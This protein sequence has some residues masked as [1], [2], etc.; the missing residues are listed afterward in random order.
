MARRLQAEHSTVL[1]K[2]LI[3]GLDPEVSWASFE[4]FVDEVLPRL[5]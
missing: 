3:G 4:L 5:A 1:F 2:P